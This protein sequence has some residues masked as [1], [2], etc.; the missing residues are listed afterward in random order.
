MVV[1]Y[2]STTCIVAVILLCESRCMS[3]ENV[4]D[5]SDSQYAKHTLTVLA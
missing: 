1:A 2:K 3:N 4:I 5:T